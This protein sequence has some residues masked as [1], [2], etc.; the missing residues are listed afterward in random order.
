[1]EDNKN[2]DINP[3]VRDEDLDQ[4][5]GGVILRGKP[6][7]TPPDRETPISDGEPSSQPRR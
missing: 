4:V 2:I 6:P 3:E 5:T 1:M 7:V